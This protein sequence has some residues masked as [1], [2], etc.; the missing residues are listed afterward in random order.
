MNVTVSGADSVQQQLYKHIDG[1]APHPY[2]ERAARAQLFVYV[3]RLYSTR[4]VMLE[5]SCFNSPKVIPCDQCAI[6]SLVK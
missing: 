6:S 5:S 4:N 3:W 1:A 2:M